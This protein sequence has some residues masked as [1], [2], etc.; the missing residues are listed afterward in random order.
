[1]T[2]DELLGNSHLAFYR[3]KATKRG[4][5][6]LFDGSIRAE[7]EARLTLEAELV[8]AAERKEFEL[9]YQPQ[10]RLADGGLIGAEALIRWRHPVRGLFS[11]AEFIPAFNTPP[12]PH[13]IPASVPDTPSHP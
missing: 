1:M 12:I 5:H 9:F 10:V 3:A 13:R 7:L 6:L 11:P 4:G 8:R 2:A